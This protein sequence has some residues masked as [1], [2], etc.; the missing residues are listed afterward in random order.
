VNIYHAK[1]Y[2]LVFVLSSC[3]IVIIFPILYYLFA[4]LRI[5][6]CKSYRKLD[7]NVTTPVYCNMI[8]KLLYNHKHFHDSLLVQNIHC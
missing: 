3:Q 7:N 1:V 4:V 5:A 6:H 8:H 2:L